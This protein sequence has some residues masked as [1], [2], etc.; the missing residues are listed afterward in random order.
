MF[1]TPGAALGL[2]HEGCDFDE[3]HAGEFESREQFEERF[4]SLKKPAMVRGGAAHLHARSIFRHEA[5]LER[6]GALRVQTADIPYKSRYSGVAEAVRTVEQVVAGFPDMLARSRRMLRNETKREQ[7]DPKYVFVARSGEEE[8]RAFRPA[9][10]RFLASILNRARFW[11]GT[12][13][14]PRRR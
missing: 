1:N 5:F 8:V 10:K 14:N 13:S 9:T 7:R 6:F 11:R 12:I 3:V 4:M 2:D